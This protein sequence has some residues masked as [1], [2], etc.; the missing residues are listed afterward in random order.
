MT[1]KQLKEYLNT[2]PPEA[3]DAELAVSSSDHSYRKCKASLET[4]EK[5]RGGQL[6]EYWGDD[7]MDKGSVP[8][9]ILEV[10]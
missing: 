7:H 6:F 10:R 4:A 1:V 2:L 9:K 8:V 3:D 5:H